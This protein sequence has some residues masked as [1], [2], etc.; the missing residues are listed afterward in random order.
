[1]GREKTKNT[2]WNE[3]TN[4]NFNKSAPRPIC[5][6]IRYILLFVGVSVCLSPS[7]AIIFKASHWQHK[8]TWSVPRPIIAQ[9]SATIQWQW[10]NCNSSMVTIPW[11][12]FIDNR[13]VV[14]VQWW[15][16]HGNNSMGFNEEVRP[17]NANDIIHSFKLFWFYLVL[18]LIFAHAKRFIVSCMQDCVNGLICSN[19]LFMNCASSKTKRQS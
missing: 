15:Q 17:F 12:K 10:F 7:I 9:M 3:E 5:S 16:F 18:L 2:F 19:G 4:T 6:I 11:Q 14:A 1:M 8:V 13:S